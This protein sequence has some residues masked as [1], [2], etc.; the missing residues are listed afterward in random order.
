MSILNPTPPDRMV[1]GQG[2]PYFLWDVDMTLARFK[3]LLAG[4]DRE[5]RAYLMAKLMRQAKPD[6]VFEFVTLAEIRAEWPRIQPFLGQSRA[7]WTWILAVWPGE[8]HVA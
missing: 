7:F 4:E 6:D 5:V 1:D 3:E 8:R 2:R